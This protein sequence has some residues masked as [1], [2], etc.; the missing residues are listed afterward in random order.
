[1]RQNQAY[2]NQRAPAEAL[3]HYTE[4]MMIAG[5]RGDNVCMALQWRR[6]YDTEA[7]ISYVKQ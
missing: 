6:Q 1:M 5:K 7:G 4:E 3:A 2:G